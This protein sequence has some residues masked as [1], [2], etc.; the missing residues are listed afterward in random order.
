MP[1]EEDVNLVRAFLHDSLG[2]YELVAASARIRTRERA[3]VIE[4]MHE[5][6]DQQT[7]RILNGF[8]ELDDQVARDAGIMGVQLR[9]KAEMAREAGRELEDRPR[10][11]EVSTARSRRWIKRVKVLAGSLK[12]LIPGAEAFLELLDLLDS[13]L[14]R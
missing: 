1:A 6:A 8:R 10:R 13:A 3:L 4:A 9:G 5:F 12:I 11:K 2:I 14:D 7:A